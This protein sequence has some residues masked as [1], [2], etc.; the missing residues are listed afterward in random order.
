ME[1]E[2]KHMKGM[3][4]VAK[5]R[6]HSVVMDIGRE[7]GGF[8]E[9]PRPTEMLISS[10]GV[11]IGVYA[12]KYCQKHGLPFEGMSVKLSWKREDSP[13]RLADIVAKISLP[14]PI[15]ADKMQA[16]LKQVEY[17]PVQNTLRSAPQ[18]KIEVG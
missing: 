10:L 9:G 6:Q 3:Q 5:M 15:P 16:F 18:A 4:F 1:I 2:V 17:C 11:C 8:D 7:E 13:T 12:S 14:K